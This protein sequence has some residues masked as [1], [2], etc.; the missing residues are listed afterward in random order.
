MTVP[1]TALDVTSTVF[2]SIPSFR[3]QGRIYRLI[4]TA[5]LK[6]GAVPVALAKMRDG[7]SMLVDLRTMTEVGA[8]YTGKYDADLINPI[9]SLLSADSCFLDVGANIGFYT[10]AI[11]ASLR[12]RNGSGKVLAF[13]PFEGN[14]QRLLENIALNGL[15][16]YCSPYKI[17]LSDTAVASE[18]TLREDFRQGSG[19][20]NAAIPTH[21]QFDEG[22]KRVAIKLDRLDDIW[23]DFEKG[24]AVIGLIKMDIEGHEDYC[25]KGAQKTIRSHRP[26]ILMEVNKPYYAA[27]GVE[28]DRTFAGLLPEHYCI[29]R[30]HGA[31]W[32]RSTSFNECRN[33]DNVFLI[34]AEKLEQ[35]RKVLSMA[36]G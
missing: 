1:S 33:L 12:S 36:P 8:Y 18:L 25:L 28:L 22:F 5:M 11:A 2:R 20:G 15:E 35:C 19:T 3:G 10:I 34:P 4:N 17:G 21:P 9:K 13:E 26:I 7:T 23:K 24:T 32:L 30:Q 31:V 27:R 29:F 16:K 14:Y 6:L